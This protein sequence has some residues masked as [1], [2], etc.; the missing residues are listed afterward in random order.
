MPIF[1]S[2]S[3]P[4]TSVAPRETRETPAG[5]GSLDMDL[6]DDVRRDLLAYMGSDSVAVQEETGSTGIARLLAPTPRARGGE[7][8]AK[9]RTP[10]PSEEDVPLAA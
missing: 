6:G 2:W 8:S 10:E 4:P 7:G 3:D 1:D 9:R 5:T